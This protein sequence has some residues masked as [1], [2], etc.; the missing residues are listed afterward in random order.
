MPKYFLVNLLL[1]SKFLEKAP[2]CSKDI[3]HIDSVI[4]DRGKHHP[5]TSTFDGS[6]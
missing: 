6:K 1:K 2:S 3:K 5:L 4:R